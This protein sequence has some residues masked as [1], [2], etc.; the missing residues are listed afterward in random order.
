MYYKVFKGAV[1]VMICAVVLA[2][3]ASLVFK[4]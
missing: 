1:F 2:T 4:F 3:M